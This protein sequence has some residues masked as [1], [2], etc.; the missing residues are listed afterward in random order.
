MNFQVFT[1]GVDRV[2][3]TEQLTIPDAQLRTQQFPLLAIKL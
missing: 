3:G 1:H 2:F